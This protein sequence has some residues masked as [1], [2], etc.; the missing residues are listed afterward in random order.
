MFFSLF[1]SLEN[2]SFHYLLKSAPGSMD[3]YVRK[4]AKR[5]IYPQS[6][7]AQWLKI[8]LI[9]EKSFE[10]AKNYFLFS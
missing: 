9:R 10:S 6:S 8:F 1:I 5:A 2:I 3:S 7:I 4:P